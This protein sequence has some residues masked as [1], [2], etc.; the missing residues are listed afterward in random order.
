MLRM[1][2]RMSYLP[3]GKGNVSAG[4]MIKLLRI[5]DAH[6]A[7]DAAQIPEIKRIKPEF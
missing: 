3:H 1:T 7:E 5:Q 4:K 2:F 6:A